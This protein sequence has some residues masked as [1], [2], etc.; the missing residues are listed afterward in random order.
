VAK[1]EYICFVDNSFLSPTVKEY[2]KSL[3]IDEVIAKI[4]QHVF[5]RHSVVMLS[6]MKNSHSCEI[7]SK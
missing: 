7:H 5:L 1:N 4:W 6:V 2:S 3:T